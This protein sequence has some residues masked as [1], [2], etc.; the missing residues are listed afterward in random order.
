MLLPQSRAELGNM[1]L[2]QHALFETFP[3]LRRDI[4]DL[5]HRER[6]AAEGDGGI[7]N[8]WIGPP[9]QLSP[10]HRDPYHNLLCQVHGTKAVWLF[11]PGDGEALLPCD[12]FRT[13]NTSRILDPRPPDAVRRWPSLATTSPQACTLAP[14]D[15]LFMPKGWW[16]VVQASEECA[17]A[18]SVNFWWDSTPGAKAR[19]GR[20]DTPP[21]QD[22]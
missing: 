10:L 19:G 8:A 2:A 7:V 17:F 13:A 14:G 9:G 16:H 5:P 21:P 1:Y 18:A 20:M 3:H 22:G 6:C 12:D 4:A 11:P 15:A